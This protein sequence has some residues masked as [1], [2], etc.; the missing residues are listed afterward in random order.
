[1]GLNT[2]TSLEA[3]STQN[4]ESIT[5]N[6]SEITNSKIRRRLIRSFINKAR[7][8]QRLD[9]TIHPIEITEDPIK[10]YKILSNS[11]FKSGRGSCYL[12]YGLDII[13]TKNDKQI[14]TSIKRS[15][16]NLRDDKIRIIYETRIC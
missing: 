8:G 4:L 13:S 6:W 3:T 11:Y 7:S 5:K 15:V 12:N 16:D 10:R 14:H 9:V 1:M 2:K